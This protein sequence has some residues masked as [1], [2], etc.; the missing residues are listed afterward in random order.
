MVFFY[1]TYKRDV[2]RFDLVR[3]RAD[4]CLTWYRAESINVSLAIALIRPL[5][6][7]KHVFSGLVLNLFIESATLPLVQERGT[8]FA[9]C[10]LI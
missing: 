8:S 6:T 1:Q 9:S 3:S 7:R 5:R 2:L 4:C 10:A